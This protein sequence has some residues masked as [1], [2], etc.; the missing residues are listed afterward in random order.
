[1]NRK[2]LIP[3]I[4]LIASHS[5]SF[6]QGS[7][8]AALVKKGV[9]A[10]VKEDATAA[11]K[12]WVGGSALEGN[13]QAMTQAN[14]LRQVEDFYG[15]PTGFDVVAEVTLSPRA[16]LLYFA[17]NYNRGALFC[18][19]QAFEAKPGQW[20]VNEVKFHTEA[21]NIFPSSLLAPH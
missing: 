17:I 11:M 20:V 18:R 10:Y 21:N 13:T 4:L 14:M 7:T 8:I 5:V 6:A 12:A 16:R 19:F 2:A 3:C 9:D 15:K 1:M